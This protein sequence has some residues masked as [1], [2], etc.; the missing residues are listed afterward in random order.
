MTFVVDR[1]G[2]VYEADLGPDTAE[3]ASKVADITPDRRWRRAEAP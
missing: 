1:D 2:T 3:A